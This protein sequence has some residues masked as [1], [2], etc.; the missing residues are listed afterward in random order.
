MNDTAIKEVA[1]LEALL[2]DDSIDHGVCHICFP[3]DEG[4]QVA[5]CG[6]D[7]TDQVMVPKAECI[8]LCK[9]CLAIEKPHLLAHFFRR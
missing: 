6:E 5:L 7:V 4:K 8:N 9:E 2:P 3:K 1:D